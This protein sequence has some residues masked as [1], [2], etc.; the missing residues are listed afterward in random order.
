MRVRRSGKAGAC[1]GF[2]FTWDGNFYFCA[3]ENFLTAALGKFL[4]AQPF[5]LHFTW[6]GELRE[7]ITNLDKKKHFFIFLRSF[8]IGLGN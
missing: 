6:G 2:D 8:K 1:K 5:F 3:R 7:E 4:T